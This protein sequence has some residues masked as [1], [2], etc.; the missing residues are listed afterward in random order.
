M[1]L[2]DPLATTEF[3][4]TYFSMGSSKML[5]EFARLCDCEKM[6]SGCV[7]SDELLSALHAMYKRCD[8]TTGVATSEGKELPCHRYVRH[9]S[10][11]R[12]HDTYV[13]V[14]YTLHISHVTRPC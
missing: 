3:R 14:T 7:D 12:I 2:C 6:V 5:P 11:S 13:R 10:V 4:V 8:L 9:V 1:C